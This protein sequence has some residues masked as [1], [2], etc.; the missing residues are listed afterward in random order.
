MEQFPNR[1]DFPDR[2]PRRT[3]ENHRGVV[4]VHHDASAPP[5]VAD[6]R[7]LTSQSMTETAIVTF[8]ANPKTR[9]IAAEPVAYNTSQSCAVEIGMPLPA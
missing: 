3:N 4:C 6:R 9:H 5:V 1:D 2:Q 8:L 7:P